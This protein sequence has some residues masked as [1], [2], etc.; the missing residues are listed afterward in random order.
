MTTLSWRSVRRDMKLKKRYLLS[1][2]LRMQMGEI[3]GFIG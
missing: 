2:K 1:P 3:W